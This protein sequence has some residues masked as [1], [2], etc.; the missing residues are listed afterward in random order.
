MVLVDL[1]FFHI[2]FKYVVI[3]IYFWTYVYFKGKMKEG[4]TEE[5]N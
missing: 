5:Q 4:N 1:L 2:L 3:E